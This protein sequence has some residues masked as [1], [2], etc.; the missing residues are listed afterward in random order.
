[1]RE[2]AQPGDILVVSVHW[3]WQLG[4]RS[5]PGAPAASRTGSSTPGWHVVHGHSSHHP[6]PCEV[7][8]DRL[9]LYGCGDLVND[10]EGIGGYEEFRDDLRLLYRA[11]VDRDGALLTAELL[12]FRSRRM[13]LERAAPADA[14]WLADVLDRES[15][16]RG[17][18]LALGAGGRI[19]LGRP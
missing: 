14:A 2:S 8:R 3:G 10:Y 17:S 15:R 18:H 6:R 5:P 7:Y 16:S 9:V 12:P 19:E 11:T 1:M 13:R 4:L